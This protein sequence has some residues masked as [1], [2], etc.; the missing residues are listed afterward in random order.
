[1]DGKAAAQVLI[2][3]TWAREQ[4]LKTGTDYLYCLG[5]R[6]LSFRASQKNFWEGASAYVMGVV[7]QENPD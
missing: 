2:G 7:V 1:M 4:G 6:K 3:A 5:R